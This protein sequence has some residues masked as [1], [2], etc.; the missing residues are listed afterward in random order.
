MKQSEERKSKMFDINQCARHGT[1][2]MARHRLHV[3]SVSSY[4]AAITPKQLYY[5]V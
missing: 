1:D 3:A 2:Q 4:L 5:I